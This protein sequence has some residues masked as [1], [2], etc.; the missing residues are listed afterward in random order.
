MERVFLNILQDCDVNG[1]HLPKGFQVE[2]EPKEA[3]S[4]IASNLAEPIEP[5]N[6]GENVEKKQ[7]ADA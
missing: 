2:V 1:L 7:K 4:L 5:K 6:T 3:A